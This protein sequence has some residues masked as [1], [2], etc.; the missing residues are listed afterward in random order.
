MTHEELFVLFRDVVQ[1]IEKRPLADVTPDSVI[2]DLGID[3]LGMMEI[4]GELESRLDIMIPDDNLV[5]L[6]TVSDLLNVVARRL[7]AR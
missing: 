4:V 6:Q 7:E 3:S 1:A 2:A 5:K